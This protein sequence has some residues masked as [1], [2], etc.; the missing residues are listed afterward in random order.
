MDQRFPRDRRDPEAHNAIPFS[1]VFN[2]AIVESDRARLNRHEFLRQQDRAESPRSQGRCR[3]LERPGRGPGRCCRAMVLR[4]CDGKRFEFRGNSQ[5]TSD[6]NQQTVAAMPRAA[7]L[8]VGVI[9][10]RDAVH[11]CIVRDILGGSNPPIRPASICVLNPMID[12]LP[13]I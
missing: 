9:D 11:R 13:G 8:D 6:S 1:R 4:H 2:A 5:I 7:R 10:V 12:H 3:V